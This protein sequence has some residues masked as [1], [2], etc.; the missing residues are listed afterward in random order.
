MFR[1][2]TTLLKYSVGVKI[3]LV[4]GI[5]ARGSIVGSARS[6]AFCMQVTG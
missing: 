5:E 1:D 2:I 6:G 3:D 4:A